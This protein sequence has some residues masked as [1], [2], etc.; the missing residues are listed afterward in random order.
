MKR[1][2]MALYEQIMRNVSKQLKRTL[3]EDID[4]N[5]GTELY[6]VY[7]AQ[8]WIDGDIYVDPT[9]IQIFNSHEGAL[10]WSV[11]SIIDNQYGYVYDYVNK[12]CYEYDSADEESGLYTEEE[13]DIE[14][15]YKLGDHSCFVDNM[16]G[17]RDIYDASR[18]S[19]TLVIDTISLN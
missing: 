18:D 17:Y 10:D 4:A 8:E 9:N 15:I 11:D 1:N 7:P 5:N 13:Q 3:N 16:D 19:Y 6:M 2:N 12:K 14:N